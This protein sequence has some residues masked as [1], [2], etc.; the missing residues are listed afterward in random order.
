MKRLREEDGVELAD[1]DD[2]EAGWAGW[3]VRSERSDVMYVKGRP[4]EVRGR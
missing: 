2:D 1:E 3:D 4:E